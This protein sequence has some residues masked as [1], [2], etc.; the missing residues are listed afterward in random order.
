MTCDLSSNEHCLGCSCC[1]S[2][3]VGSEFPDSR[4]LRQA[5]CKSNP[6][7]CTSARV[8]VLKWRVSLA[9]KAL[10]IGRN[11]FVT[12]VFYAGC[13]ELHQTTNELLAVCAV[14]LYLQRPHPESLLGNEHSLSLSLQTLSGFPARCQLVCPRASN[15]SHSVRLKQV[16]QLQPLSQPEIT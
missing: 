4:S 14:F 10:L 12:F 8:D 11:A 15:Y 7:G 2:L 13:A 16:C 3:A 1:W 5:V 9:S 6:D